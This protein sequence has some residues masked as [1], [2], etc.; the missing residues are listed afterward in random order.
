M[1]MMYDTHYS[2]KIMKPALPQLPAKCC[3]LQ[4]K[5]ALS[6]RYEAASLAGCRFG[7]KLPAALLA[8]CVYAALL[9]LLLLPSTFSSSA[10]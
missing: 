9:R 8:L 6:L 2:L 5:Q 4:C 10:A 3:A 1:N 7:L